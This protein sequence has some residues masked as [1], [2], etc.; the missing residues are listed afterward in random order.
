M[1]GE[2]RQRREQLMAKITNGIA[3]FRSAIGSYA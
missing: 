1:Q 3:I 2:Y